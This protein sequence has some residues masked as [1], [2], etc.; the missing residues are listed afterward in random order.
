M[1]KLAFLALRDDQGQLQVCVCVEERRGSGWLDELARRLTWGVGLLAGLSEAAELIS[2]N[3][4]CPPSHPSLLSQ[5]YIDKARL[6]AR[7]LGGFAA[8]KNLLDIGDIVGARE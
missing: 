5:V 6:E 3:S 2:L 4:D 1:G 7:Q 8:L